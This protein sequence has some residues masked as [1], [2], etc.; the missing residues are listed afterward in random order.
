MDCLADHTIALPRLLMVL[1]A[2]SCTREFRMVFTCLSPK[3]QPRPKT[4]RFSVDK[5]EDESRNHVW[6]LV[7]NPRASARWPCQQQ[8]DLQRMMEPAQGVMSARSMKPCARMHT[9][10]L[11]RDGR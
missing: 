10:R 7:G 5:P 9:H 1:L 8:P 2:R 4:G 11:R 3:L 6:E